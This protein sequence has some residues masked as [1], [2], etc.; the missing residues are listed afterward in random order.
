MN[1]GKNEMKERQITKVHL[2]KGGRGIPR[3]GFNGRES[4]INWG[5]KFP[6][7]PPSLPSGVTGQLPCNVS[8]MELERATSGQENPHQLVFAF[9]SMS[10]GTTTN[11]EPIQ[12]KMNL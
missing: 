1:G 7:S 3:L 12:L 4:F 5:C 10:S 11:G 8:K 9:L 2:W 6:P